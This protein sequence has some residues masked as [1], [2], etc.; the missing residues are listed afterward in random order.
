[1]S[2]F[3][4]GF[5]DLARGTSLDDASG[6]WERIRSCASAEALSVKFGEASELPVLKEMRGNFLA[7]R[8]APFLLTRSPNEDTSD[9]LIS[10]YVGGLDATI[11]A[12][13]TIGRWVRCTLLSARVAGV[14]M[15]MTEGFD[16]SFEHHE[17]TPEQFTVDVTQRIRDEVDVPSLQFTIMRSTRSQTL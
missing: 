4:F 9:A 2:Y 11:L 5:I 3:I 10:P 15:W 14:R 6:E 13:Q 1:M 7:D 17:V 12:V 8:T 16:D